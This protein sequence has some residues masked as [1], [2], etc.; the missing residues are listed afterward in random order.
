MAGLELLKKRIRERLA[1]LEM[2]ANDASRRAGLGLSY[3]N[4]LLSGKSKNPVPARLQQLADVLDCDLDYLMGNVDSPRQGLRLIDTGRSETMQIGMGLM[5]VYNVA[6]LDA[7]GFF[8]PEE[9]AMI[10]VPVSSKH[11]ATGIYGIVVPDDS[12]SPRY[13]SGEYVIA[14]PS[15]PASS[16]GFAV[17]RMKDGRV[18]IRRLDSIRFDKVVASTLDGSDSREILRGDIE[19]IH[20]ISGSAELTA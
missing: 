8:K 10:D 18:A 17:L 12:M 3:V 2:S 4:D 9:T 1:K 5:P 16:G 11:L 20:R 19:A 14:Q 7:E 6:E 15:R 13:L